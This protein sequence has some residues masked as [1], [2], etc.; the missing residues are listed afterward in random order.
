MALEDSNR[1]NM[2]DRVA[3]LIDSY[4]NFRRFFVEDLAND[5]HN[6]PRFNLPFAEIEVEYTLLLDDLN[7][8]VEN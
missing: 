1:S 2:E 6:F 3:Y 4:F 8:L 5:G 7:S